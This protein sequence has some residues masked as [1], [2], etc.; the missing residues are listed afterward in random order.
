MESAGDLFSGKLGASVKGKRIAWAGDC[1]GALPYEPG[2]LEICREALKAFETLGCH[3]EEAMPDYPLDKV[4]D[5]FVKLR[6]RQ[7]GGNIA[8]YAAYSRTRALLKPE[9]I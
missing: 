9:A 7:Q 5:A 1:K 8:A 3:V 4:W 2:V 6:G